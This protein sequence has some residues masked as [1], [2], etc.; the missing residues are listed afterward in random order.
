M[1][2]E[3][4]S[5]AVGKNWRTFVSHISIELSYTWTIMT[6]GT[7]LR[8]RKLKRFEVGWKRSLV[9]GRKSWEGSF[10]GG[11]KKEI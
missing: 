5:L 6:N 7:S 9:P 11:E 2:G 3:D 10:R 8:G 1:T 4:L